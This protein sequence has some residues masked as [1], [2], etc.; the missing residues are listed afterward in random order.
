MPGVAGEP[1]VAHYTPSVPWL[2]ELVEMADLKE[3][4]CTVRSTALREI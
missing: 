4:S 2:A 1:G 3:L